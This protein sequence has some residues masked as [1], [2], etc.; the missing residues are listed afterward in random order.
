M[1]VSLSTACLYIYPLRKTFELAQRAGFDGVELVIGPEVEWRG[2]DYVRRLSQEYALPVLSVHPPLYGYPG[3]QKLHRSIEPYLDK[4][5]ALTRA[6]GAPLLVLHMPHARRFDGPI[7]RGF[8]DKLV[9]TRER[10]NGSGPLLAL[11]NSSKFRERDSN[12]ILRT[13]P[14]L[15]A[16]ANAYDFPMTLDTAHAG[17]WNQDLIQ[18]LD[19]FDGRLMNVH[20]SDLRAVSPWV[21]QHPPLHS[22]LRQHQMPGSGYLPLRDFLRELKARGYRGPITYEVSPLS[23]QFWSPRRVEANLRAC[24]DFVRETG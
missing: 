17:T 23:L 14:E 2:G 4:A 24:V 10:M 15:R 13:L 9:T 7:G 5:L 18:A 22:Y 8:V 19:Y 16:F 20:L 1:Q 11:E 3:W 12:L 21:M 6:V